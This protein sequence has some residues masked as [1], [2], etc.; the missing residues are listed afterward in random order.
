M[1]NTLDTTNNLLDKQGWRILVSSVMLLYRTTIGIPDPIGIGI[2][3]HHIIAVVI[4]QDHIIDMDDNDDQNR[5]YDG[6]SD[7]RSDNSSGSAGYEHDHD[8]ERRRRHKKKQRQHRR[9]RDSDRRI[10]D[11]ERS[12]K[13]MLDER[14]VA[15]DVV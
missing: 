1:Y 12:R 10:D 7:S 2:W 3:V 4:L 14:R 9:D 5:D 13:N 6:G 15:S 8:R 11:R